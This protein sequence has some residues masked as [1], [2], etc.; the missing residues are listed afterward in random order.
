M[1]ANA[2]YVIDIAAK[3]QGDETLAQLDQMSAELMGAGK[4]AEFFQQAIQTVTKQLDQAK[5]AAAAANGA[6]ADGSAKYRGLEQAAAQ[7]SKKVERL[8]LKG[9]VLSRDYLEAAAAS[10]K[11]TQAVNDQAVALEKLEGDA[12]AAAKQQ[13]HLTQTLAGVNKLNG[14]VNKSLAGQ[15]EQFEKFG[16]A[17]GAV[18][19]PLGTLGQGLVRPIQGFSK[20][21]ASIGTARAAAVLGVVGFAALAAAALALAA[22]FVVATVKVAAWA[23][24]LADANR[25]AELA[26]EAFNDMNP[27]L[28]GLDFAGLSKQTGQSSADLR[29]LA[30]T[31][32]GAGVTADRM[33]ASLK[34]AALAETALGKG[35]SQE[36]VALEQAATDA[37]KAVDEAAKKSGGVVSKELTAKLADA[38]AAADKFASTSTTKLGGVVARQMRGLGAQSH[39]LESNI[40]DI[41]SGLKIDSVLA[42]MSKLVALFDKNT[43][44]GKALQFLFEKVFQPIIDQAENAATVVE[45]FYLGVLIGA[46]KL[47]ITLKPLIKTISDLFGFDDDT[48]TSLLGIAKDAG[49]VFAYVMAGVVAVV[50]VGLVAALVAAASMFAPLALAVYAAGK[51][52]GYLWDAAKAVYEYL[53]NT[54]LTQ[55]ASDIVSGFLSVFT[56]IPSMLLGYFMQAGAAVLNY[57]TGIDLSGVGMNIMLGMVRGITAGIGAVVNAVKGAMSSAIG[58]AKSV[59]GIASPSKVFG[60]IGGFTT[61]GYTAAVEDGTQDAQDAMTTMLAVPTAANDNAKALEQAQLAGDADTVARLQAQSSPADAGAPQAPAVAAAGGAGAP[62]VH[63]ENLYLAGRK[64]EPA[65]VEQVADALTEI[66]EGRAAQLGAGKAA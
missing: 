33:G 41:F 47:Y 55:I 24:G 6:L 48:F 7:A 8:A 38:R 31:L 46:T 52:L 18:G 58:A 56:A 22:A 26:T 61:E 15:A 11:A 21:S 62:G 40:S 59:L 39:Q 45:A 44:A 36:Y 23:V 13:E 25:D 64:A 17:L 35:A 50:G 66:L 57:L 37:Q 12:A 14:H 30:K 27:A 53:A 4:D 29:A 51:A 3:L 1:A 2:E 32:Q 16:S 34:A 20:L 54:S 63:I 28:A 43:T 10:A 49:V 19:G 42:G 65:E 60:E 9:D 5:A